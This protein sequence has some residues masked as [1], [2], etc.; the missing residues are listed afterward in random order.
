[1][2]SPAAGKRICR[3]PNPLQYLSKLTNHGP[4]HKHLPDKPGKMSQ[5]HFLRSMYVSW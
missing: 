2:Q 3:L 4:E 5:D 1:M